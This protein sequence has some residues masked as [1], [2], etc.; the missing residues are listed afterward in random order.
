LAPVCFAMVNALAGSFRPPEAPYDM[1]ACGLLI[2][3]A[4]FLLPIMFAT[5]QAYVPTGVSGLGNWAI[6]MATAI[7]V[8]FWLLF[9]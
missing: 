2:A 8:I 7:N 6:L 5:G 3:S 9:F 4:L 1:L